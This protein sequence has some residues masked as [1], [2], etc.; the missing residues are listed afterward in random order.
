MKKIT[1]AMAMMVMV[2]MAAGN[3][4]A[5]MVDI[6]TGQMESAEFETLKAMV[7]GQPIQ[8]MPAVSTAR[9]QTERYGLVEMTPADF[10][11]LRKK[12]AGIEEKRASTRTARTSTRMVDIGMGEMPA[13][14]FVALKRMVK[15]SEQIIFDKLAALHP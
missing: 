4:A 14:D 13:D 11:D 8:A 15:H 2:L 3:A 10:E 9:A 1:I 7:N 6:G 5:D 12:V